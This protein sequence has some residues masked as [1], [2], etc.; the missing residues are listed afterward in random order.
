MAEPG[1]LSGLSVQ[2]ADQVAAL[3]AGQHTVFGLDQLGAVGLS[4]QAVFKRAQR[5]QLFRIYHAVY[6][7]VPAELV[8][9]RGRYLAAVLACGPRAV[10][11]HRSAADLLGLRP[12]ATAAIDVT[13]PRRSA[14][15]TPGVTVHRSTTLTAADTIL[16][17]AIPCTNV[18]RC[19]LD[20]AGVVPAAQLERALNQAEM[21]R[22]FDLRAL[23]DQ[24]ARNR[25]TPAATRLRAALAAYA[26]AQPAESALE[27]AFVELVRQAG[28][29]AP[30]RQFWIVPDDGGSA[31]RADFAW[32][33]QRLVLETDGRQS[34]GTV[35]AFEA[36]RRRD[37]RLIRAGWRV[38][39]VTW[40]QLIREPQTVVDLVAE[41]LRAA[42]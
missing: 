21:L 7:L 6:S 29:P 1:R 13:V 28:L 38:V 5:S 39:R 35:Q 10:L 27:E 2:L 9:W 31:I 30:E 22:V 42:A 40:T 14:R 3:A 16:V 11:S 23:E 4:A 33:A 37:Q 20:L 32:P 19:L 34:H 26:G 25:H 8:P 36:D 24:I 17:D 12:T 18:A 15:T 41:L